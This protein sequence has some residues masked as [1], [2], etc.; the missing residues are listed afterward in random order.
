MDF[1]EIADALY[2]GPREAFI[3]ARAERAAEAKAAGDADLAKRVKALRKPST[4]AWLVNQLARR[5][6][7]ELA[8][9][10]D[11][12]EQLR[13]AHEDLDGDRLRRLSTRRREAIDALTERAR[14]IPDSP[15]GEAVLDQVTGT[16][17]AATAEAAVA[18]TV[19][20]GRL[21]AAVAPSGFE[22]WLVAPVGAG[23]R[24]GAPN[25]ALGTSHAPKAALGAPAPTAGPREK[26]RAEKLAAAREDAERAEAAREE[27]EQRLSTVTDAAEQAAATAADLRARLAAAEREARKRREAASAARRAFDAAVRAADQARRQVQRLDPR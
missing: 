10:A 5:H 20:A 26:A 9:L 2:G 13:A 7:D 15:P 3:P 17:Q 21:D 19:A 16:L 11:L 25:V 23:P 1:E 27:A 14:A 18:D 24:R 4:A 6:R 22:Q 8:A 12:G